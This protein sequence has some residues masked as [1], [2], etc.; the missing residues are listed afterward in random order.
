MSRTC[1]IGT[2]GYKWFGCCR[3]LSMLLMWGI[4]FLIC[5]YVR[6]DHYKRLMERTWKDVTI[7]YSKVAISHVR[8]SI[9]SILSGFK[10][11]SLRV[12]FR[13]PARWRSATEVIYRRYTADN[14][15]KLNVTMNGKYIIGRHRFSYPQSELVSCSTWRFYRLP[16]K[17]I[18]DASLWYLI[19]S[20]HGG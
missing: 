8:I 9:S 14:K 11:F 15:V 4:H 12:I 20:Q 13:Y 19:C 16:P 17:H 5:V 10:T 7:A 6:H 18:T 3:G 2:T 1:R